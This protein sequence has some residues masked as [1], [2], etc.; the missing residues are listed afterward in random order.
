VLVGIFFERSGQNF[1]PHGCTG[2]SDKN[3]K[4]VIICPV[5]REGEGQVERGVQD[6]K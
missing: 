5:I 4:G 6:E 1:E 2:A 3:T